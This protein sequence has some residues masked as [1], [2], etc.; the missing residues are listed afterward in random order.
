M[1]SL[2]H[3]MVCHLSSML[4]IVLSGN[5]VI[6]SKVKKIVTMYSMIFPHV[7]AV[8]CIMSNCV[9]LRGVVGRELRVGTAFPHLFHVLL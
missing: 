6:L 3:H 8:S 9:N 4:S 5:R 2:V 7:A 1:W